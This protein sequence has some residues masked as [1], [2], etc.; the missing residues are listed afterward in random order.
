MG[1]PRDI[2]D[3]LSE[4]Q[5]EVEALLELVRDLTERLSSLERRVLKLEGERDEDSGRL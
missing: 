4:R 2:S 3:G 1:G 5:R